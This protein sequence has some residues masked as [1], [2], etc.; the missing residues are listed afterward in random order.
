MALLADETRRMIIGLVALRPRHPAELA[1][2]LRLSPPAITRQLAILAEA[3]LVRITP[4][5]TDRRGKVVRIDP[6]NQG[7]IMA[8]L[9]GTDLALEESL[10]AR[11]LGSADR[12]AKAERVGHPRE[13]D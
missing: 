6:D 9:A 13:A 4:S 3:H 12:S 1:A 10:V 8:W 7:R 11:L 2:E 5:R